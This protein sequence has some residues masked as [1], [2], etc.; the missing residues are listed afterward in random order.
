MALVAASRQV[1]K[2]ATRAAGYRGA[3]AARFTDMRSTVP[4]TGVGWARG[5]AWAGRG[6][7]RGLG[8]GY[9]VHD[10][11]ADARVSARE[12]TA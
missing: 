11:W 12:G 3:K 10:R 1:G 7:W 8:E 4:C 2:E 5:M 6:V 9:G